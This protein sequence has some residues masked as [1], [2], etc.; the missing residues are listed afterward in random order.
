MQ[1]VDAPNQLES[2]SIPLRGN[3]ITNAA[4]IRECEAVVRKKE[5]EKTRR[6][7]NGHRAS[8]WAVCAV[9]KKAELARRLDTKV[10]ITDLPEDCRRNI[11]GFLPLDDMNILQLPFVA[12]MTKWVETSKFPNCFHQVR[13]LDGKRHILVEKWLKLY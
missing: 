8:I 2:E 3:F 7:M 4:W 12:K 11:I 5:K 1:P 13:S 9:K 10:E 6:L